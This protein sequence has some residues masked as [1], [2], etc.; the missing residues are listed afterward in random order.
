M[1][2]RRAEISRS[3]AGNWKY[4]IQQ[5]YMKGKWEDKNKLPRPSFQGTEK[6]KTLH[7]SDNVFY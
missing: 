3:E 2:V 6:H 7:S 1:Q 5:Q 4:I